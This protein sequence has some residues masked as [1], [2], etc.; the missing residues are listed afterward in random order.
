MLLYIPIT[1]V[2]V[3]FCQDIYMLMVYIEYIL[4]VYPYIYILYFFNFE[5][6]TMDETQFE[7]RK[8]K[9]KEAKSGE[10]LKSLNSL[11]ES[12]CDIINILNKQQI[13]DTR[14]GVRY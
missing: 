12:K 9:R 5:M 7:N 2:D 13:K 11:C 14:I 10:R 6:V 8:G 1:I 4:F 3:F